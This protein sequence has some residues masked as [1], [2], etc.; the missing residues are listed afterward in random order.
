MEKRKTDQNKQKRFL[1]PRISNREKT[2]LSIN[3][4]EF[5]AESGLNCACVSVHIKQFIMT[6][7][8]SILKQC[9]FM[10]L[11]AESETSGVSPRFKVK[12]NR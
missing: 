12:F 2:Q 5:I 3:S 8:N 1:L 9:V 7:Q 4:L 10:K 11:H 6:R